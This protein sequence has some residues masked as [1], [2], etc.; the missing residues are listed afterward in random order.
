[1]FSSRALADFAKG[2][3]KLIVV[4]TVVGLILWPDRRTVLGIPSMAVEDMLAL[5]RVQATKVNVGVLSVMTL[6]ALPDV[7]YQRFIH[8]TELRT[9]K[10]Q[11]K[12]EHKQS[13]RD[14]KIKT[15]LHHIRERNSRLSE[16]S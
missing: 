2:I 7:I 5:V 14:Q 15:S 12:D 9:T 16:K 13:E 1:M 6:V 10:Q 3:L 8:H 4:G 11:V